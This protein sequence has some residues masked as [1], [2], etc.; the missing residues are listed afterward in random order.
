[1]ED[2]DIHELII[3]LVDNKCMDK[4]AGEGNAEQLISLQDGY[5]DRDDLHEL[6]VFFNLPLKIKSLTK[7]SHRH[8]LALP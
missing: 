1:M 8:W 6:M 3:R 2:G 5:I 4:K 7:T